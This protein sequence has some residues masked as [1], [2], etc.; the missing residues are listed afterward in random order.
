MNFVLLSPSH[1]LTVAVVLTASVLLPLWVRR[2]C[3]ER[4]G[5]RLA[6]GLGIFVAVQEAVKIWLRVQVYDYRLAE[7]LPLHLCSAGILLTAVLLLWRSFRAFEVVYFWGFSGTL[8]AILTRDLEELFSPTR[9]PVLFPQPRP[10]HPG[11]LLRHPGLPFS[12]VAELD[13]AGL[14]DDRPLQLRSDRPLNYLL[15]TNYVY[16]RHKPAGASL[17]DY[18]GPW[19]WYM[20]SV[21]GLAWLFFAVAYAPFYVMDRF[22]RRRRSPG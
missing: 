13:L 7:V 8:Q 3:S 14:P 2:N 1:L 20:L 4:Q 6:T 21:A 17:L 9:V 16:L 18:L 5:Q 22:A 11:G 15:D 19:P 10:H 12:T